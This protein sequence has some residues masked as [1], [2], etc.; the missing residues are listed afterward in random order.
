MVQTAGYKGQI[1]W[2]TTPHGHPNCFKSKHPSAHSLTTAELNFT[3]YKKY[4]WW[5]LEER[6][7]ISTA[8]WKE[9]GAKILDV[10]PITN[11]MPLWHLGENHPDFQSRNITDCLHYCAP[12]PVYDTWSTLL[13]NLLMG[14]LD[15]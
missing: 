6:N 8:I 3:A 10:A 4:R 14:R 5:A 11:R 1:I 7:M 9:A 13:M 12:G 15:V 2:R